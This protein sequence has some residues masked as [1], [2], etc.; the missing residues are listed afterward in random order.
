MVGQ[1]EREVLAKT[2]EAPRNINT[3]KKLPLR[4]VEHVQGI[5]E[6]KFIA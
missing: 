6:L 3:V 4:I 5:A 1:F 2:G